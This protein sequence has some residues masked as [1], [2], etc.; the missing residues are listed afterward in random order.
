ML[1]ATHRR[2]QMSRLRLVLALL[3]PLSAVAAACLGDDDDDDAAPFGGRTAAPTSAGGTA[4]PVTKA[5]ELVG[6]WRLSETVT[7]AS[8]YCDGD[9]GTSS[10]EDITIEQGPGGLVLTGFDG[11]KGGPWTVGYNAGSGQVRFRGQFDD[12]GGVTSGDWTLTLAGNSL[13]GEKEW[14]WDSSGGSCI[15]GVSTVKGSR[16]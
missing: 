14:T 8:Q 15:G 12:E 1:G 7:A 6:K 10:D 16:R 11:Q 5:E 3:L 9:I 2:L 4:S 13:A